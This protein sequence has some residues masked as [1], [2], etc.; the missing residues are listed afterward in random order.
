M[1]VIVVGDADPAMVVDL[2]ARR[3]AGGPGRARPAPRAVGVEAHRGAPGI[4]VTDSELTRSEI[5]IDAPGPAAADRRRRWREPARDRRI[6][7][8]PGRSTDG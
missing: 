6:S 7:S 5:S 8:A 2:I 3:F 4:V 1:T